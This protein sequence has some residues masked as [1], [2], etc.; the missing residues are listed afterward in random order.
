MPE[1]RDDSHTQGRRL[2]RL[3]FLWNRVLSASADT[4]FGHVNP[5]L[6][7]ITKEGV[8]DKYEM[9]TGTVRRLLDPSHRK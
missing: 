2:L 6:E 3:L 5:R 1:M 4:A 7:T 8:Y 9:W